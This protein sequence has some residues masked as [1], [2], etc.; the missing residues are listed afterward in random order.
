MFSVFNMFN[1]FNMFNIF[2]MF[3]MFNLFNLFKVAVCFQPKAR[4]ERIVT[5]HMGMQLVF[6]KIT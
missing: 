3:N 2:N 1:M 5:L 4:R 6:M